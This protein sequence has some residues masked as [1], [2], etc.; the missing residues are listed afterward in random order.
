MTFREKKKKKLLSTC[1]SKCLVTSNLLF[2]MLKVK[3]QYARNL[4]ISHEKYFYIWSFIK[5]WLKQISIICSQ[6]K[7][8]SHNI[9][10]TKVLVYHNMNFTC[11]DLNHFIKHPNLIN[12][13]C[14]LM[15][16]DMRNAKW[17]YNEWIN[18]YTLPN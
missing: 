10:H 17:S 11:H 15:M 9:D 18:K 5:S 3:W 6:M 8:I 2:H 13:I 16:Q 14:S 4:D 12:L 1:A 7:L